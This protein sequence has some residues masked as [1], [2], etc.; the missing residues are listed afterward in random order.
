MM[1]NE[2][3]YGTG[4][5]LPDV[6]KVALS[7]GATGYELNDYTPEGIKHGTIYESYLRSYYEYS[8]I[9]GTYVH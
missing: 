2:V 1:F 6:M 3:E 7:G 9:T 4:K 5:I 8:D